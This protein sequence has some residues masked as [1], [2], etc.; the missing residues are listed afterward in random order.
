MRRES[1]FPDV[2]ILL[3]RKNSVGIESILSEID[4]EINRLH[5]VKRLLSS[6]GVKAEKEST[7][8]V[9]K[10]SK[11]KLS[12]EARARIAEAQRKRWAAVRKS[13]KK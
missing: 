6:A 13:E 9:K 8:A 1:L 3:R 7:T 4:A 10:R 2:R 5:E 11:R 12:P